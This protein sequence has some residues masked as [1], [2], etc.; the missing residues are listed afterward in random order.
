MP[1]EELYDLDTDPY[2]IQTET[3]DQQSISC[4]EAAAHRAEHWIDESNDQG[5]VLEPQSSRRRAPRSPAAIPRGIDTDGE[6]ALNRATSKLNELCCVP[7][8]WGAGV[9][10]AGTA[11][12]CSTGC[13][14]DCGRDV[15]VSGGGFAIQKMS[16]LQSPL[17]NLFKEGLHL[18]RGRGRP[19]V[20][21]KKTSR[22]REG[23]ARVR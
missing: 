17:F 12:G 14:H 1:A 10:P 3:A 23:R 2:E 9:P 13:C 19:R 5:R 15:R 4:P 22:G 20:K 6:V 16:D 21:S 18:P 8:P 7:L 11:G